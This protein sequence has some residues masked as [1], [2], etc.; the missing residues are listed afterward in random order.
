MILLFGV[1]L[2]EWR[3]LIEV[4]SFQRPPLPS[5]LPRDRSIHRLSEIPQSLARSTPARAKGR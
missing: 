2:I 1:F 3:C 4:L 5:S